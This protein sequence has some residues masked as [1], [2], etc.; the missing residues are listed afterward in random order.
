MVPGAT[1]RAVSHG[2]GTSVGG[3]GEAGAGGAADGVADGA[4]GAL[5]GGGVGVLV[6][7]G[8]PVADE[9][10]EVD[11]VRPGASAPDDGPGV[12]P[13]LTAAGCWKRGWPSRTLT[14]W[15]GPRSRL[16]M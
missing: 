5:V 14:T 11:G 7:S 1:S 12:G 13:P 9:G 15:P 4:I 3:G 2:A 6:G 16:P 10:R 8:D